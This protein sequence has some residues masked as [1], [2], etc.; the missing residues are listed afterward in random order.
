MQWALGTYVAPLSSNI[1]A[2]VANVSAWI[3]FCT[4][5]MGSILVGAPF[6]AVLNLSFLILILLS[7]RPQP[8]GDLVKT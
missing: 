3:W 1:A 7:S 6:N 8:E 2:K 5:S 4:D